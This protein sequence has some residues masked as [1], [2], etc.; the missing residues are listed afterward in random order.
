MAEKKRAEKEKT[1]KNDVKGKYI[2]RKGERV[3][4]K[5]G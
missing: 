1:D 3:K 4:V 5:N 2:Q